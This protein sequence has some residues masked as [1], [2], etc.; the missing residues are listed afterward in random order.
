MNKYSELIYCGLKLKD[1]CKENDISFNYVKARLNCLNNSEEEYLPIDIKLQ[2]AVKSYKKR[3]RYTDINYKELRL[4]DFCKKE[5]IT[6]RR[7]AYRCRYFVQKHKDISLLTEQ[8]INVF[9]NS[10]YQREEVKK[11][12]NIFEQ[13][14]D[15]S[16]KEYKSICDK[17]SVN[18]DKLKQLQKDNK[19][20]LRSLIYICWYSSDKSSDKGI[21]ISQTRLM[22]LFDKKN[23]QINDLYGMYKAGNN[24]FL[25]DILKYEKNYL[26]GFILR[27]VR[28][29]N[30]KI[31]EQD[32]EDLLIEAEVI[33]TKC[34]YRNV[35]NHIGRIIR[36]L[37]KSVTKQILS[38][39]IKN[40][41]NRFFEFNDA[42][43]QKQE[44]K[45]QWEY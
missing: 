42:I 21:Y 26:I 44:L 24:E 20:D 27:V 45:E 2:L 18:Y 35:F 22:E 19:I 23:L 31:Y 16:F 14:N 29:Y 43:K 41:S 25:E 1:Y 36:Y 5:Q 10:Y 17:L 34:L 7:I 11:L 33:L 6:Y 38:Y 4:I 15:C 3:Y 13:L 9:I 32:Y 40:Y 28:E 30:F 12:K 8:Q 37:E 39:L